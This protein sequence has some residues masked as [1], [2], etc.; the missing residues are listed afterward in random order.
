VPESRLEQLGNEK[1]ISLETFRKTGQGVRTPVWFVL[2]GGVLYVY[3]VADSG[4]VKRIR[5]QPRVRLA[6]CDVRGNVKGP[7]LE[8]TAS[9]VE[10]DERRAADTELDRKYLLKRLFKVFTRLS[11]RPRAMIKIQAV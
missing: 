7:W 3:A 4:K 2:H 9:L 11:R 5:N 8:A 10:G 6:V 1:Y